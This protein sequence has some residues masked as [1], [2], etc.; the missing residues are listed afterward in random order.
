MPS[1]MS[2][3]GSA[4]RWEARLFDG[5]ELGDAHAP[6]GKARDDVELTAEAADV[7]LEGADVRVGALLELRHL[8]LRGAHRGRERALGDTAGAA[9]L[10]QRHF[11][12]EFRSTLSG[13][14]ACFR[15]HLRAQHTVPFG[16]AIN[17]S[18]CKRIAD[19]GLLPAAALLQVLAVN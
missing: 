6:V 11:P 3:Q 17:P 5:A 4:A 1:R 7:A 8:G 16:H 14:R 10:V 12:N 19:A 13:A 2:A 18:R 9:Q 15:R